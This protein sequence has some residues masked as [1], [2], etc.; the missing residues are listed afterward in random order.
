MAYTN[1][2][3]RRQLESRLHREITDGLWNV[4]LKMVD[5]DPQETDREEVEHVLD[6]LEQEARDIF[7][8]TRPSTRTA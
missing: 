5:I 3:Y 7:A 1:R 4:L 2:R 6:L 8:G